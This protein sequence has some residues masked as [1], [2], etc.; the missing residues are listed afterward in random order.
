MK[1]IIK[2]H[3]THITHLLTY[4]GTVDRCAWHL[5]CTNV[6]HVENVKVKLTCVCLVVEKQ[7]HDPIGNKE[8]GAE[9]SK[10]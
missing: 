5:Q 2:V 10:Q 6:L 7:F 3:I 1:H 8:N 4:S 9:R